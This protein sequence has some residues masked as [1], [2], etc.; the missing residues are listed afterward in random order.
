[1]AHLN[2]VTK[3]RTSGGVGGECGDH[4]GDRLEYPVQYLG[5]NR[6]QSTQWPVTRAR[7]REEI[8]N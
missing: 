6:F 1:M 8:P 3:M 5:Q 7:L 2:K 4:Q